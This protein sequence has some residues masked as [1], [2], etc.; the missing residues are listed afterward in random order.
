MSA[1][2]GAPVVATH[3][4]SGPDAPL[5]VLLHGRGSDE[6]EI[7]A[8]AGHLPAGAEY[9]AVRAPIAEG[10]GFAWF[11]NRGV[12]RPLA[13]S[14]RSTMQWFREW[15]DAVAPA[16]RPVLLVGFSGGAAFAGGLVLDDPAR[17]SGAAILYG[18][19]PFDAGLDVDT[20][21]L[22]NLPVFVAQGETDTVIPRELLDRTWNFLH[23]ESGAPTVG[24]R[25]PGGHGITGATLHRLA[26][27]VAGR[28]RYVAERGG[29]P[30]G[31]PVGVTWPTLPGG[32]LP[33]RSGP[34]PRVAWDIPQQQLSQNAPIALQESLFDS[35][36]ALPG[37]DGGPS[38][39]S[40][41][42]ARA[43]TLPDG[44]GPHEAYL[45][46]Q[47]REFA[48]LHPAHDGSLHLALPA[49]RAADLVVHGWGVPHPWAG[50]R[51]SAGFVMLFGP[52]DEAELETVAG[53]VTEAYEYASGRAATRPV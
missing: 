46:P 44:T 43:F 13:D 16:G 49:A 12:G 32:A 27:W 40:V 24:R 48:H 20:G 36:R 4:R 31:V 52:R 3:G 29:A 39:I 18:T 9:A 53:V 30:V 26:E 6:R 28:L 37:I 5:V 14:L 10:S 15:L 19:L 47:V 2:F 21:R 42:G 45:V 25:D 50:T 1:A 34:R 33:H 51:L 17:Y 7:L 11:A 35:L 22:A 41:P 8:L 38:R 23:S